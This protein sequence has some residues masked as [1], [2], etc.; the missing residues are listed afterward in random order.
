MADLYKLLANPARLK[1]L[2]SLS[3]IEKMCVGDLSQVLG[4]SIAATS[5]QLKL[6]RDR[7]WLSAEG[8][9]KLVY[10]S[11]ANPGLKEALEGDLR[12]LSA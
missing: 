5:H 8:D 1:I 11:L 3:E 2:L 10:Y 7:G 6:L 9:G 4:L 12:F